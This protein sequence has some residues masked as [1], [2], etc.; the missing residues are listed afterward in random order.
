MV[1]LRHDVMS[2]KKCRACGKPLKQRL[3]EQKTTPLKY[4]YRCWCAEQA[5]RNHRM[6]SGREC[7][8]LGIRR[9]AK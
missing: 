8:R 2:D 4:C 1:K 7:R 3:V 5:R 9:D 6:N